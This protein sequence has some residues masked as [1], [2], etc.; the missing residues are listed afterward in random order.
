LETVT[1]NWFAILRIDYILK[2]DE[3]S[4]IILN[5]LKRLDPL[6][7]NQT[8]ANQVRQQNQQSAQGQSNRMAEEFASETDVNEVRQQNQRS[9]ANKQNASGQRAN[10]FENLL[11]MP[12]LVK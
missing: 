10:R 3:T 4:I 6:Q 5:Y 2:G 1:H 8:N 9:E 11:P 12:Y 7:P